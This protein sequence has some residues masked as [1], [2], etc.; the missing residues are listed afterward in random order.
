[1]HQKL[2]SRELVKKIALGNNKIDLIGHSGCL[3]NLDAINS[4]IYKESPS[5]DYNLRL[6][7]QAEKQ[8]SFTSEFA[9]SPKIISGFI[10]EGRYI[11]EMEYI[12]GQ[13]F[14]N[15]ILNNSFDKTI[16]VFDNILKYLKYNIDNCDELIELETIKAKLITLQADSAISSSR[17][18]ESLLPLVDKCKIPLGYCHGDLTFENVLAFDNKVF[19]IDFLDSYINSPFIDISKIYQDL[20]FRWSYR[21]QNINALVNLKLDYLKKHLIENLQLSDQDIFAIEI[22]LV[23]NILRIIPYTDDFKLKINLLLNSKKIIEKWK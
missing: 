1:M 7:L 11:V 15:F 8:A 14:S 20:Y 12:N 3:I 13:K 17:I 10:K 2:I 6:K 5:E 22:L 9:N 19:F 16:Y 18:I 23:I 4:L 21:N